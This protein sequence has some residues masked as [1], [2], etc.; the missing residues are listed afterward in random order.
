[1]SDIEVDGRRY[2]ITEAGF[3]VAREAWTAR[4][5]VA[6]AAAA[7]ID[8]TSEHWEIILFMRDYYHR[9]N[10]LPNNRVFVKAVRKELGEEKGNSRYLYCLFPDGPLK[11]ACRIGGLPKPTSCI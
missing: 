8:L 9:F 4:V 11:F 7:G 2:E 1:M 5:G 6:L 3:L 10:H